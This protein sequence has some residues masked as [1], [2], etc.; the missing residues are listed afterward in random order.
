MKPYLFKIGNFEIRIYS[1]MYIIALFTA[2]FIAKRD[3]VA[4]KRGI[5]KNI[6]EDYAYFAIVSGLIGARIY[7]VLL[8][9][10]YYSQNVSEIIKVWHGGLAIHGGII[11]GIL[12]TI[13]FAKMKKVNPLVLMDMAVGPLILGQGLGRIGN[14]ANGEIHGF[15]TITPFSVILKGN[16]N[17]WWQEFQNMP[18]MKQLEFKELVPWGIKFPLDSPA[19]S[20]FPNMKLHPAMI[21]EL[22]FNFIAFY[23]IWFVFRKKEYSKGILTM[24]YIIIY[25]IIRIIV[26]TFRAEDLLVY[27]IRAPY[28]ISFLMIII[29]VVGIF[30]INNK[31]E[32]K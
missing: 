26:S 32:I 22:I 3:E 28:I 19:G 24:I 8:K 14:L 17:S 1:L 5:N 10:G 29:G 11:G 16:F 21:Y 31:K 25:G 2:I 7:Y 15:P 23:L 18:L 30:I 27:G 12:G 20:E 13:I 4:E 9:W 6:I